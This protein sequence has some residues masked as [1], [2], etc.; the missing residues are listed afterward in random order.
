M[1]TGK[2]D[3]T[4]IAEDLNAR[5]GTVPIP[6]ILGTKEKDFKIMMVKI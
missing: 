2:A 5:I 1:N 3:Y 4:I 6:V